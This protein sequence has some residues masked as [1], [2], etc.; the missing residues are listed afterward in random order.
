MP[1][2]YPRV[3]KQIPVYPVSMDLT[4]QGKAA[5]GRFGHG[6]FLHCLESLYQKFTGDELLYTQSFGKPSVNSY[7]YSLDKLKELYPQSN[8]AK[9]YGIG[10]NPKSDIAGINAM[11]EDCQNK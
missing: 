6:A 10:D 5:M 7:W 4:F 1:G 3:I 11:H 9:L 8:I 2:N